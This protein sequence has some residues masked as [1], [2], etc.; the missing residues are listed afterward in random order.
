MLLVTYALEAIVCYIL[1]FFVAI[2]RY[3]YKTKINIPAFLWFLEAIVTLQ[4]LHGCGWEIREFVERCTARYQQGFFF[5]LDVKWNF[6]RTY[7]FVLTILFNFEFLDWRVQVF[8]CDAVKKLFFRVLHR[9]NCKQLYFNSFVL[10]QINK[11]YVYTYTPAKG[12]ESI[13][14]T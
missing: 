4:S 1:F 6:F 10:R 3:I 14:Y 9:K 13:H 5:I 12:K 8:P 2:A 7:L 11:Y